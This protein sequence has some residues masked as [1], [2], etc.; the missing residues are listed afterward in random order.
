MG[1]QLDLFGGSPV[2]LPICVR[3]AKVREPRPE[4]T[5]CE[6]DPRQMA[7]FE[8]CP[9]CTDSSPLES[10]DSFEFDASNEAR[11]TRQPREHPA[12]KRKALVA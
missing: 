1:E 4:P 7:L 2:K 8:G 12:S 5:D 10:V 9:P 3:K 6:I 11:R